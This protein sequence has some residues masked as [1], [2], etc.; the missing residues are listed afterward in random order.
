MVAASA[1][2]VLMTLLVK[3]V[4]EDLSGPE[5]VFWR[6]LL[7]VPLLLPAI[8]GTGLKIHN[9]RLFL[10][11]VT[12]GFAAMTCYTI[13]VKGLTLV[14]IDL[15]SKLRPLLIAAAAPL[16]LGLA[17]RPGRRTWLALS[18]GF[19]GCFIL[20]APDLTAGSVYAVLALIAVLL[21]AGA[22]LCLRGLGAT[23]HARVIVFWFNVSV[24]LLAAATV[25]VTGDSPRLPPSGLWPMLVGVAVA[26][27]TGQLLMTR[28]YALDRASVVAGA[29]YSATLWAL[30]G[31]VIVFRVWPGPLAW[32]GGSL[33]FASSLWL[34]LRARRPPAL[35]PLPREP[36]HHDA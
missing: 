33:V 16:F 15:V 21:S 34:V 3:Q 26:A 2:L 23:E 5:V 14:D 28:A 10:L 35:E 9:K 1:S 11:R 20:L 25:G 6:G 30:M 19:V 8:R 17:E 31:D 27:T 36:A 24:T 4:R 29:T 22:H 13:S 18:V 12:L 7:S 32:I